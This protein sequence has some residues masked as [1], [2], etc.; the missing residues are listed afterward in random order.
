MDGK[1]KWSAVLLLAICYLP[2]ILWSM[3]KHHPQ[4]PPEVY[5]SKKEENDLDSN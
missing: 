5:R 1:W 3:L 4:V 2:R